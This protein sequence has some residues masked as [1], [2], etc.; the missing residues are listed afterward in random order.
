MVMAEPKIR[1]S[2]DLRLPG[3]RNVRSLTFGLGHTVEG[4]IEVLDNWKL[5]NCANRNFSFFATIIPP[6]TISC[7]HN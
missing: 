4:L 2:L 7:S 6:S 5:F 3:D 1:R